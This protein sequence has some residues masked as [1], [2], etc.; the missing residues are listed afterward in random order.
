MVHILLT[1][2]F[3]KVRVKLLKTNKATWSVQIHK[4]MEY[5][6]AKIISAKKE[7][8][9]FSLYVATIWHVTDIKF[10]C[11]HYLTVFTKSQW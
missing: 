11:L 9:D 1:V 5:K 4:C 7:T 2:N 6:M 8:G 3:E 10:A